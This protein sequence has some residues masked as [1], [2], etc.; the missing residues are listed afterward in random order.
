[1]I[2]EIE[3]EYACVREPTCIKKGVKGYKYQSKV[4]HAVYPLTTSVNGVVQVQ[5]GPPD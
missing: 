1:M 2:P 5:K 4:P 3:P